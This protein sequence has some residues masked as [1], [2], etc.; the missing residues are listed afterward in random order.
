MNF[1]MNKL[2]L[3]KIFS[4]YVLVKSDKRKIR[5]GYTKY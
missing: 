5:P 2:Y 1:M 4:N 3:P